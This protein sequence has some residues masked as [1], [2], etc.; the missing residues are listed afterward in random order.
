MSKPDIRWLQC[1]QN[2]RR[3][4]GAHTRLHERQ[5]KLGPSHVAYHGIDNHAPLYPLPDFIRQIPRLN[6]GIFFLC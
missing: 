6:L 5:F 3:K 2:F 4:P 1:F